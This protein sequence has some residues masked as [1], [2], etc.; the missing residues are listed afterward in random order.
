L[1]FVIGPLR[2]GSSLMS[3]CLDDH[4]DA[5]C[6]CESEISR[7]LIKDY[8]LQLHFRRMERHGLAPRQIVEL[9]NLRKQDDFEHL[10][11]WYQD[12]Q[13]C[14]A[15]LY[16]K[17]HVRAYGD[18]SPDFF[19][20]PELVAF[21]AESFPLIYTVRDP[22]AIYR[23]IIV[24]REVSER[25]K[26]QRW[27]D[28]ISNFLTW[29]PYLDRDNVL[30]V[31]YEDLLTNPPATMTEVYRHVGL[32]PSARFLEP[33]E[34]IAPS[35]FLWQTAIDWESGIRREFDVTRIDAWRSEVRQVDL[36]HIERDV[37]I[38]QFMGRF[39]YLGQQAVLN[40]T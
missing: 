11:G 25:E 2:T 30:C 32:G 16:E 37:R 21:L 24:Q 34:R 12:S 6:L 28:F 18:K 27:D 14:L 15:Q 10:I 7:A 8:F 9:L 19:R 3:R 33:F 39:G 38:N 35:R 22:R 17:P 13:H 4:P 1:F 20:Y 29:E 31:R 40:R 36:Q 26:R 23:S 5:I